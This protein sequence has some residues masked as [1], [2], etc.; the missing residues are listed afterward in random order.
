EDAH[1]I[2]LSRATH[3]AS[4]SAGGDPERGDRG[5]D[6]RMDREPAPAEGLHGTSVIE[7]EPRAGDERDLEAALVGF[8]DRRGAE[9]VDRHDLAEVEHETRHRIPAHRHLGE[10]LAELSRARAP[11][12]SVD[13]DHDGPE[14]DV[15]F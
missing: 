11:E 12:L 15:A 5:I 4:M 2:T 1:A 9:T 14:A 3:L 10:E 7:L 8:L 6:A 13:R